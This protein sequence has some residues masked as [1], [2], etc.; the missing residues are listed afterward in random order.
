MRFF[1]LFFI[2]LICN[3]S[4]AESLTVSGRTR[5]NTQGLK[6]LTCP[7]GNGGVAN[8]TTC[9]DENNVFYI[10]PVGLQ[11]RIIG[12]RIAGAS[13]ASIALGYHS[14]TLVNVT[15]AG[16]CFGVDPVGCGSLNHTFA[17][18]PSNN[19]AAIAEYN[20]EDN[21]PIVPAG[22]YPWVSNTANLRSITTIYGY[23][24]TP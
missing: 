19:I 3:D 4:V 11:F 23:E 9:I 21:G 14:A 22:N 7:T 10:V 24:E 8:A 12:L 1:I 13:N 17:Y 6:T 15:K 20:L 2:L 5:Y 16:T 18:Y